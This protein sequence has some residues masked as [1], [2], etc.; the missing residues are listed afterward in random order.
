MFIKIGIIAGI[1][2]LGGMIFSNEITNLFPTTSAAVTD[3]LKNDIT[4]FTTQSSNSIEERINSS[5]D[6]IV[7]KTSVSLFEQISD[8]GN[9]I[10]GQ[11]SKAAESSQ[12]TV[13]K[14]IEGFDPIKYLQNVLPQF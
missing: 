10:T 4:N 12:K 2:I 8:T 6:K 1:I 9:E 7:N 5:T 3:T 13:Q 14:G 11:I